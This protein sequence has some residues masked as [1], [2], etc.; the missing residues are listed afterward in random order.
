MI[1]K[2]LTKALEEIGFTYSESKNADNS[3]AYAVY[4]GYL[5]TVY[6]K[7]GKKI[8]Y[9]NFKF[10][11]NEEND[12]KKYEKGI[13]LKYAKKLCRLI[14]ETLGLLQL[15]QGQSSTDSIMQCFS[16]KA[17]GAYNL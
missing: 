10:S 13:K 6:E 2:N 1:T 12:I 14:E 3:N 16:I 17:W 7:A 4:G 15:N 9:I 11:D 8:A 5:V